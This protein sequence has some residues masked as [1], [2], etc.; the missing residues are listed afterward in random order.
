MNNFIKTDEFCIFYKNSE[1]RASSGNLRNLSSGNLR[2][3]MT[4][5]QALDEYEYVRTCE[6][7]YSASQIL[8]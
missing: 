7:T 1:N 8:R 3:L 6:Y 4:R 2:N 5:L